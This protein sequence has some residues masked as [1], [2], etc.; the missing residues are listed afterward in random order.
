MGP[1]LCA[2]ELLEEH[3]RRDRAGEAATGI[4]E[5]SDRALK[6]CQVGIPERQAPD[7]ITGARRRGEDISGKLVVVGVERRKVSAKRDTGRAGECCKIEQQVRVVF[8]GARQ[9]IAENEAAFGVGIV[10]LNRQALT[11]G[12][13]ITWP[14]RIAGN[15]V[16]GG[17]DVKLQVHL[18]TSAHHEFG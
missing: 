17:L 4:H 14:E 12:E 16:L 3:R 7:R 1:A 9:R 5:I 13:D 2:D 8:T 18:Q 15:R 10:D 6:L 11:A